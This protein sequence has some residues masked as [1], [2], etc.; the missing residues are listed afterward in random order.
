M[1]SPGSRYATPPVRPL[2]IATCSGRRGKAQKW[3]FRRRGKTKTSKRNSENFPTLLEGGARTH[4]S[5]EKREREAH[6]Q[7][8]IFVYGCRRSP[9]EEAEE[10]GH[11]QHGAHV[12][13]ASAA[14][15]LLMSCIIWLAC[16]RAGN[17]N[18]WWRWRWRSGGGGGGPGRSRTPTHSRDDDVAIDVARERDAGADRDTG[19]DSEAAANAD[20]RKKSITNLAILFKTPTDYFPIMSITTLIELL[21]SK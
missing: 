14:V 1:P 12:A 20:T 11:L 8:L 4:T 6:A 9:A 2:R 13:F 5:L 19:L 21:G 16:I 7:P 3:G 18:G 15:L 17:W 10:A